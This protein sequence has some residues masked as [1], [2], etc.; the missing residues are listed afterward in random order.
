MLLAA[1]LMVSSLHII[2]ATVLFKF[3]LEFPYD[4]MISFY[5]IIVRQ[6]V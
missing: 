5:E 6:C 3:L 4:E 1:F 2:G